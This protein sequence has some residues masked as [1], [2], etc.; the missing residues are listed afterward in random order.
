MNIEIISSFFGAISR[1]S[2][3]EFHISVI[4]EDGKLMEG[5]W[6][7]MCR[8][9]ANNGATG[10]REMPFWLEKP[11]DYVYAPFSLANGKYDLKNFNPVYF[12]NLRKMVEIANSYNLKFYFSLYEACNIKKKTRQYN[13]WTNNIQE[14]E[15]AWYSKDADTARRLWE[16]RILETFSGLNVGYELC[17]EPTDPGFVYSGFKTYKHLKR[18]GVPDENIVMGVEWDTREYRKFRA[19][20]LEKYGDKWWNKQKHK[21]FS[22]VHNISDDTFKKLDQ[23]EG[24]TRRFWLSTDGWH[25]KP[26]KNWW[27]NHLLDFFAKVP[28]APFKNKYAFETMHKKDEDDF[29]DARGIS[30]AIFEITGSYPANYNRFPGVIPEN[31]PEAPIQTAKEQILVIQD[32]AI[33]IHHRLGTLLQQVEAAGSI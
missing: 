18:K 21:W 26:D 22:T 14:L 31:P 3:P 9:T 24:H 30:E 2:D 6:R 1:I 5:K 33:D 17:N 13:P 23:Q 16:L 10:L 29:D 20:F 7:E 11:E 19:P 32:Q 15:N 25:P 27:K 12:Q 28:T 4:G 8:R